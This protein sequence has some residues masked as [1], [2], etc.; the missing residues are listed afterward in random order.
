MIA[1]YH[2]LPEWLRWI[3]L[4]PLILLCTACVCEAAAWIAGSYYFI[5]RQGVAIGAFVLFTY[6]FV[7]RWQKW[8]ALG[9]LV[10]RVVIFTGLFLLILAGGQKIS[11]ELWI[12]LDHEL[13]GWAAGFLAFWI[14][15]F[16]SRLR[17]ESLNTSCGSS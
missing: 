14:L 1:E 2:R 7:P 10:A 4:L 5:I 16:R 13:L 11:H 9:V 15:V 8:L 12:E 17:P 3:L 6:L